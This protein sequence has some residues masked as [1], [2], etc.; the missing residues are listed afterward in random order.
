MVAVPPSR[1]ASYVQKPDP[2]IQAF[3]LHGTDPGLISDHGRAIFDN[4]R[5]G[6]QDEPETIKLNEDDLAKN[7]DLMSI[8]TQTLSMFS[9]GKIVRV[10]PGGR[11]VANLA[12]YPWHEILPNV[13]LVVEAGNLRK[14]AKLRKVFEQ[15]KRLAAIPCHDGSAPGNLSRMIQKACDDAGVTIS[16]EA[17]QRLMGLLSTDI[18]VARSEVTKL[19]T[20]AVQAGTI[21]TEDIDAIIGD[22]AQATLDIVVDA[23]LAN[24]QRSA[25]RYLEK[26]QAS[27]TP[28]DT[29]LSA[30]S[31]Q[32]VR[33]LRL[34]ATVDAGASAD[35]AVKGLRPPVHFRRADVMKQQIKRW[36]RQRLQQ[37]LEAVSRSLKRARTH[38]HIAHQIADETILQLQRRDRQ[39]SAVLR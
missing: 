30:L 22:A 25:L 38:P 36:D 2:N 27:G 13:R 21:T 12:D 26:L 34:R 17:Q 3:L 33:L 6:F 35:T 29:V 39:F 7:P 16:P 8:E 28:P 11:G 37:A 15:G 1:A 10:R 18:G 4:L 5:A 24:D 32:I 14:D 20:Y 31:Q 23:I 9:S 19:I